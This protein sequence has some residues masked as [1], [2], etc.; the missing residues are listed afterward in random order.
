MPHS[1]L[2]IRPRR[3]PPLRVRDILAWADDFYDRFGRWPHMYDGLIRNTADQTWAAVDNALR[4]GLR[5]LPSGS[6]L[7]KLLL[8]R[9]GRRHWHL[10]SN[11]TVS[12]ILAWA[13]AH[14]RRTGDW[15]TGHTPGQIPVAP[16][17]TSWVAVELALSRGKRGLPGGVTLA[18]LLEAHRGVRNRLGVPNLTVRTM[19]AWADDHNRRTGRWPNRTS[20]SIVVAPGET[21]A[22]VDS[23]LFKGTRGL[24]GGDSLARFLARHRGV[25]N[26]SDLP[27]LSA[28]QILTW[29]E[30]HFQRTG[31]W[32]R[33]KSGS[34]VDAPGETWAAVDQALRVGQRGLPGGSSLYQLTRRVTSAG[35]NRTCE[36]SS[37]RSTAATAP[38]CFDAKEVRELFR[39]RRESLEQ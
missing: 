1:R 39:N 28:G 12:R 6:S 9:R 34:I 15:P 38:L 18:Q 29:A 16:K 20:G 31:R 30:A 21:W 13:D 27:L 24:R 10:P 32:P 5:G 33:V 25:R 7:A 4:V 26:R 36:V 19:L 3:K 23:A 35:R 22:A 14:L 17:G 2:P 37:G 11:L 8:A